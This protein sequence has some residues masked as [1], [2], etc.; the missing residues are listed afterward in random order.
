MFLFHSKFVALIFRCA[1]SN[2]FL[3]HLFLVCWLW[4]MTMT[5]SSS[6]MSPSF[7]PC[8]PPAGRPLLLLNISLPSV[9]S[10]FRSVA[11]DDQ[12]C[13]N[14]LSPLPPPYHLTE[15]HQTYGSIICRNV[16]CIIFY[17]FLY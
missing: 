6:A 15:K 3:T 14:S 10:I 4:S 1:N 12:Q 7:S 2:T 9:D 11:N 8:S 5:R 13:S 17:I 16:V